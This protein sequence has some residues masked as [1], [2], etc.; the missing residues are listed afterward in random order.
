MRDAIR[1]FKCEPEP[2]KK[3]ATEGGRIDFMFLGAPL[4][5]P[6]DPLLLEIPII[7]A[8]HLSSFVS[9]ARSKS[10][11]CYISTIPFS[12]GVYRLWTT[13]NRSA[14]GHNITGRSELCPPLWVWCQFLH[15]LCVITKVFIY[16]FQMITSERVKLNQCILNNWKIRKLY[17]PS[18]GAAI[19]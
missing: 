17:M 4:T 15:L 7:T 16:K 1:W 12:G 13:C 5:R 11:N 8:W 9:C 10:L 2:P 19:F 3:M 14:N 18:M 6:L